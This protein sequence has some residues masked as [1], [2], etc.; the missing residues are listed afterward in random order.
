MIQ[1]DYITNI[2]WFRSL[3]LFCIICGT[4]TWRLCLKTLVAL[5]SNKSMLQS[6]QQT[7][8]MDLNYYSD[9]HGGLYY[10]V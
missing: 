4:Q 3:V 2:Q 8:E 10:F 6:K 9:N 5:F 7:K 1:N